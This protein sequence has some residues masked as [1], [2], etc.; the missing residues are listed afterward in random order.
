MTKVSISIDVPDLQEGERFYCQAL[1]CTKLRDQGNM[2]VISAG[3][4]DIYLL[5]KE[6]GSQSSSTSDAT[7]SFERHWTPIHLDFASDDVEK[8][9][10][11]VLALGGKVEGQESGD[12]GAIAYCVDPFGHGFCLI[13]E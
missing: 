2:C 7:R 6:A 12:W 3:N 10:A 4:I 13:N 5:K 8:S 11:H 1:G 9:V